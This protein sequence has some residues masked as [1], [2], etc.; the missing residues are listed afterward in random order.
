MN[1]E[2]RDYSG[3]EQRGGFGG[4][5]GGGGRFA[6]NP[7]TWAPKIG[8]VARI[9]IRIHILFIL[10]IGFEL[11]RAAM[12]DPGKGVGVGATFHWLVVLFGSVFLHELGHCFAARHMNGSADEVLMWPLG[13][14]ATVQV[15]RRPWPEFVTVIWGPLVNVG[16]F[17]VSGALL[18][19]GVAGDVS[20]PLN[21]FSFYVRPDSWMSL[22]AWL[23]IIFQLN[24]RLFLFNLWPMFPMDGGRMLQCALWWRLDLP[25]A[26]GIT[27]TVGMV[28][29]I[30]MGITGLVQE[31]YLLLA[32]AFMGY[33]SCHRERQML[34]AGAFEAEG[35]AGHDFSDGYTSLEETDR[36]RRPGLVA[37]W[38]QR[39]E[40]VRQQVREVERRHRRA[41]IDRILEK[42]H[43]RGID[44]L[45]RR[46]K[47]TLDTA[48]KE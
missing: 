9:R 34:K 4:F 8:T 20:L 17:V 10:F 5:G 26:V 39:R 12:E 45:S 44:S 41:E 6:D 42:V 25:R 19:A 48:S 46:E 14:L 3:G 28:A 22:Q 30:V 2:Q 16:L 23:L 37:R 29:A 7:L 13:G 27:T 43:Q 21:P 36:P 47:R 11:L 31:E 38:R 33:L 24:A 18:V 1:W 32:I 35:Y 15:P 40:R